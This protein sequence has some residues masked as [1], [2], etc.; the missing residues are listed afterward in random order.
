MALKS[1]VGGG[2]PRRA[3]R[4]RARILAEINLAA[5]EVFAR[6]GP[7][8]ASTQAIAERAGL[9]KQQLHYYIDSKEALYRQILQDVVDDWINVFGFADEARGPR[10]VLSDLIRRKLVFSFEQPARSRLFAM[11]MMRGA[12]VLRPLMGTSKRRTAQAVT[13]IQNW[14]DQGLMDSGNPLLLLFDIWAITQFYAD[15]A[16]Q[17]AYFHDKPGLDER[18]REAVIEHTI[19]LVLRGA[20]VK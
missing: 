3:S 20:G 14:I 10:K 6:E 13:V 4:P 2:A 15:H 16:E 19:G 8:G 1:D 9:S 5:I 17:V 12:P 18:D 7:S 11:E